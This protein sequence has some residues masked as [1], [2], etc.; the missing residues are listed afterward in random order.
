MLPSDPAIALLGIYPPKKKKKR[1]KKGSCKDQ[2]I[3]KNFIT[4]L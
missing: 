1:K 4:D 2:I 3:E